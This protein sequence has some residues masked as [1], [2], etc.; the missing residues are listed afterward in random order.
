MSTLGAE[1]KAL[2]GY[3]KHFIQQIQ[4]NDRFSRYSFLKMVVGT[5]RTHVERQWQPQ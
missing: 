1:K 2:Y 3:N 4:K 5:S